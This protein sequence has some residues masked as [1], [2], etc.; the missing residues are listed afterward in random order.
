MEYGEDDWRPEGPC[1]KQ[2]TAVE[3]MQMVA[4]SA[5]KIGKWESAGENTDRSCS[6]CMY[7]PPKGALLGNVCPNCGARVVDEDEN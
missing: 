2:M 1:S 6:V 5:E 3:F 4:R 7:T